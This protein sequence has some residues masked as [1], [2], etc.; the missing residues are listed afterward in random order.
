MFSGT[1][2][3]V[4]VHKSPTLGVVLLCRA[5]EEAAED[6]KEE[7]LELSPEKGNVAFASAHDGWAFRTVQFADLYAAKLGFKAAALAR[8]LWGD[9]R[10]DPKTKHICRIK[11]AQ[12]DK[13]NPLFVQASRTSC[14]SVS[15]TLRAA[16]PLSS[17]HA[18]IC[19]V[20]VK[21]VLLSVSVIE[22]SCIGSP[23][24]ALRW[25]MI[26]KVVIV[27]GCSLLWSLYGRR[28]KRASRGRTQRASWA[29]WS[30]VW[31][32]SM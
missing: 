2:L 12:A 31:A 15:Y 17:R 7:E 28:M 5:A 21:R 11:A 13:Y 26:A 1:G 24:Q 16:I 20:P 3:R 9:Y 18:C 23:G 29:R 6:V 10:I 8:V 22:Y 32:C 30:R 19:L 25:G 14:N 27:D 4:K